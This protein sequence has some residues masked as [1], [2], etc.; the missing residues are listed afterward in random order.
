[1]NERILD[2][3]Q[4]CGIPTL[5]KRL[6]RL[7]YNRAPASRRHHLAV[8]NGLAVH[9]A[10]VT[11]WLLKIGPAFGC[12]WSRP[13]SPYIIGMLHDLAKVETYTIDAESGE[14]AWRDPAM[15][16]HGEASALLAALNGVKLT[17]Q[18]MLCIVWHMGAYGLDARGLARYDAALRLYPREILATHTADMLACK[19][20][21]AD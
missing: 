14:V 5:A 2:Y 13:E 11:D 9:S 12:I 1:M 3:V 7:G 15:P 18:E 10:N 17:H 20:T 6:I 21:E 19:V 8:E 4:R 16:G